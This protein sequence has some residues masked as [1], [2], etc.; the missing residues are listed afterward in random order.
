[1]KRLSARLVVVLLAATVGAAVG[2]LTATREE[3]VAT[4]SARLRADASA[5][6]AQARAAL[7]IPALHHAGL[8]VVDPARSQQFY[9]TIWPQGEVTT[10]AGLP[11][12]K[13]NMPSSSRR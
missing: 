11:A 13:S 7:P 1:M 10:F 5:G 8:N 4:A 3:V 6:Q 12:H 9:K 2:A